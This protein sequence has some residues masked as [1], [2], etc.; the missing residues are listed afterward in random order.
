M[1]LRRFEIP[2]SLTTQLVLHT[3]T[4]TTTSSFLYS[5]RVCLM[6]DSLEEFY[7]EHWPLPKAYF[8]NKTFRKP[9]PFPSS[10][11]SDILEHIAFGSLD[12]FNP[13]RIEVAL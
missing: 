8:I 6:S 7:F 13:V 2:S 1:A 12:W 4:I 9:F 3:G 10:G 11:K 5:P